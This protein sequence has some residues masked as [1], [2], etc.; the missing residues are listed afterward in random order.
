MPAVALGSGCLAGLGCLAVGGSRAHYLPNDGSLPSYSAA[1]GVC[2]SPG[3]TLLILESLAG[4][5]A[6]VSR[7]R[8]NSSAGLWCLQTACCTRKLFTVRVSAVA[9][10]ARWLGP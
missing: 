5:A 3:L 10:G 9:P 7:K 6:R 1:C 4:Q 8:A 2:F